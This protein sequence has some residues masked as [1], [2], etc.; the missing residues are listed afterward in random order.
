[1]DDS[2]DEEPDTIQFK[3][4]KEKHKPKEV[5]VS[6]AISTTGKKQWNNKIDD[7]YY[8]VGKGPSR[9]HDTTKPSI[10]QSKST[11]DSSHQYT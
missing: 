8:S 11:V 7:Q 9:A 3:I 5:N 6:T 10:R 1:M 2:D 4:K